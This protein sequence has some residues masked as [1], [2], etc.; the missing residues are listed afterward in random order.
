MIL[1]LVRHGETEENVKFI[2]QG[3]L[4]QG[5]LTANGIKQALETGIALKDINIDVAYSSDLARA[6]DTAKE[7]MAYHKGVPFHPTDEIREKNCGELE[8]QVLKSR[9]ELIDIFYGP[10]TKGETIEQFQDRA[11]NFLNRILKEHHD[12]T[13]LAI[14]HGGILR[15]IITI[16]NNLPPGEMG[17]LESP[18]NGSA[19]VLEIDSNLHYKT[20]DLAALKRGKLS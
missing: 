11:R 10:D 8:G 15:A 2:V 3:G 13:V 19:L 16:L 4:I 5:K 9:Q 20:L 7:I 18:K 6:M 17:K 14:A 12:Q 1:I